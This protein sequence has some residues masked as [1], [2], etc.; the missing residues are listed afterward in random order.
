MVCLSS[1]LVSCR[2]AF[3]TPRLMLLLTSKSL[4]KE[5]GLGVNGGRNGLLMIQ[6][7]SSHPATDTDEAAVSSVS[8]NG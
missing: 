4:E 8:R 2:N 5:E 1:P 3:S 7:Q 6:I